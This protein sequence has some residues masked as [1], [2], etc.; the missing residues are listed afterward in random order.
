MH[1]QFSE[2]SLIYSNIGDHLFKIVS[3]AI[4]FFPTQHILAQNTQT[5]NN[6][7]A[8]LQVV[9]CLLPGQVRRLGSM[10]YLTSRRPI[11]TTAAD[12][13]IR[14]GEYVE[15]DRADYKTAL[16]VWMPTA[17]EGNAEA[18]A[19]VGEIF[20]RGLGG[21]PNYQVAAFWYKKS[22]QQGN[23]R[24]Q[25]NLATLYEQGLGVEK[26]KLLALNWYRKAWGMLEE[27]LIYQA[28]AYEMQSE[29]RAKYEKKINQKNSQIN[30]LSSQ[31][32]RLNEDIANLNQTTKP[33]STNTQE[34]QKIQ[35]QD[36]RDQIT[37]LEAMVSDLSHQRDV[38]EEEYRALPVFREPKQI[39][40]PRKSRKSRE[41]LD[42]D[43]EFG[44]YFAL[45]IGNQSYRQLD[46][47]ASPKQ[48]V[49]V[50]A[51]I[52]EKQYGFAVKI[53]HDADDVSV[54]HAINDLNEELD[55]GD[56]LLI[57]YAGHG[58]RLNSGEF[59]SGYWLPINADPP[60]RDTHWV[61]N[62]AITRHLSRLEAKR[63]LVI[64][65]S[66]YAGLLS[67]A[68]NYL[69][70]D[71]DQ[72]YSEEFIQYKLAKKSRL[73]ISS[74]GDSPVLDNEGNGHSVFANVLIE[75][76]RANNSVMAS[77][78][79]FDSIKKEVMERS[80]KIGHTQEPEFK[81]IKGSG[82]E[83][84]DFFFVPI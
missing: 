63:I 8:D 79:L 52:L 45:I 9:D 67:D 71:S 27:N 28:T 32:D 61:A 57:Y 5:P 46:D 65:D 44:Q 43:L 84:G 31:I 41:K 76:L 64:A 13:R 38:T 21:S 77:P 19:N 25:F 60:P 66:C 59:T 34:T 30:L 81:A 14:G 69:F 12:C 23:A 10:T 11:N 29:E 36:F 42:E 54:M 78:E 82:H 62:E 53:L 18:Q 48:D 50:I 6:S 80:S 4:L 55:E 68:P 49:Q 83:V 70:L 7:V 75:K 47:L 16:S 17:E 74:G 35:I 51:S 58:S 72:A 33:P 40:R 26:N 56:N 22:A 37:E 20:E 73:L 39:T 3:I 1:N 2:Q 24:A 15:Y